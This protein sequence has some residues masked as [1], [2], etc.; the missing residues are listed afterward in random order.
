MKKD[1]SNTSDG[2]F[3]F[4]TFSTEQLGYLKEAQ[5]HAITDDQLN[6]L[7]D[8]QKNMLMDKIGKVMDTGAGGGNSGMYS[9]CMFPCGCIGW[10]LR[11]KLIL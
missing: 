2:N 3:Y 7:T 8:S 6:S 11:C 9:L 5:I 1:N 10:C 4:Q